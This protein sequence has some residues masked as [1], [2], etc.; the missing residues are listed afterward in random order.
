MPAPWHL[1]AGFVGVWLAL[2]GSV[3]NGMQNA[4]ANST[5]SLLSLLLLG[6]L[7]AFVA[8][9]VEDVTK[10]VSVKTRLL[11]TAASGLLAA[12]LTGYWIHYVNVPGLDL[13]LALAPVGILFTAIAVAGI[14]NSVNIIDGF[15]GLA[16]MVTICML[17]SLAYVALQVD[18]MF[19]L[20]AALMGQWAVAWA[21]QGEG[22]A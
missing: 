18:D 10:K 1:L 21:R 16:S 17:L 2:P 8:G 14:A 3:E 13:L 9:L 15:N 11:A 19:I 20:I 12:L 4:A 6:A 7:P 22:P 5:Q